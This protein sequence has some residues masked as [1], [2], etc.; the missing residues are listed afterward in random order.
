M[1]APKRVSWSQLR[2]G[3]TVLVA[4]TILGV[5]I[6]LLTGSKDIFRANATLRTFMADSSG[7]AV[8]APVRLNGILV[9][10]VETIQLSGEKDP[11]RVVVFVMEIE[12]RFLKEIPVDSLAG[13]S[14]ANLLG[15]KF[16]NITK[17]SNPQTVRDGAEIRSLQ[18]QDIPELM[19][20]SAALLT[21]LQTIVTRVDR[22]L[23]DVEQGKGNIGKFLRDEELYVRLNAIGA[24]AQRLITDVRTGKGTLSRL[25]Y[26]DSLYEELRAPIKRI[27]ALLAE[28][29]SGRGTAGLLLKDRKLYDEAQASI[30]EVRRLVNEVNA[31]KGTAGRLL[32][33][34]QLYK[35]INALLLKVDQTVDKLNSGQ[36]TLG[37]LMVNPQLYDSMTG[38]TRELN[39]LLK[40]IRAN[41][42]KFLSIKL[43]IF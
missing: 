1:A 11:R 31:G 10:N 23:A 19:A 7:M 34:E 16:I 37:Q 41:P 2:V 38:A 8:G 36:G 42:K 3:V 17:G 4:L 20:Q 13:I 43:E 33:D 25:L 6:F 30:E 39:S 21:T 14:A 27:D 35:N 15:D 32:K 18:S 9:G 12:S 26:D 28:L 40:D 24:E 22:L 29:Q 5:L